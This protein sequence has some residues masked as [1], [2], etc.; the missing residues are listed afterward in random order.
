[1]HVSNLFFTRQSNNKNAFATTVAWGKRIITIE[2]SRWYSIDYFRYF[3]YAFIFVCVLLKKSKQKRKPSFAPEKDFEII[4]T[5]ALRKNNTFLSCITF[6][7]FQASMPS[8]EDLEK[9]S[10]ILQWVY[11]YFFHLLEGTFLIFFLL[12]VA[13]IFETL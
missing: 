10:T 12:L 7:L 3:L 2:L 13:V 1:M 6:K 11:Q 9:T 8:Y 5:N 4:T